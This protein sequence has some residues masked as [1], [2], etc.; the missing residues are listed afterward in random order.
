MQ[1]HIVLIHH[2]L[3]LNKLKI[4]QDIFFQMIGDRLFLAWGSIQ[5]ERGFAAEGKKMSDDFSFQTGQK[6]LTTLSGF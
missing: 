1:F 2:Q 3:V 5:P 4:N 6:G